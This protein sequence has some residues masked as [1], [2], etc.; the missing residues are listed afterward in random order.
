MSSKGKHLESKW[1]ILLGLLGAGVW[2]RDG[3]STITDQTQN[4]AKIHS[5]LLYT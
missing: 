3:P 1:H 4:R 2:D 5:R